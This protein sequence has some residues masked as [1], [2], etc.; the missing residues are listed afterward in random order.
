M[1]RIPRPKFKRSFPAESDRILLLLVPETGA[2]REGDGGGI[3]SGLFGCVSLSSS[4]S[5]FAFAQPVLVSGLESQ[6]NDF[7]CF[8]DSNFPFFIRIS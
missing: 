2:S 8:F 4:G 1:N 3:E 6:F 7:T 5:P